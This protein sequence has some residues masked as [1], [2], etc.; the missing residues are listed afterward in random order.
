MARS[1]ARYTEDAGTCEAIAAS[2]C[3]WFCIALG[4]LVAGGIYLERSSPFTPEKETAQYNAAANTWNAGGRAAFAL[5]GPFQVSVAV[6]GSIVATAAA[7]TS[8]NLEQLLVPTGSGIAPFPASA[9]L[10][11]VT[12]VTPFVANVSVP[13]P[14]TK[15]DPSVSR[16]VVFTVSDNSGQVLFNR[17]VDLVSTYSYSNKHDCDDSPNA[18]RVGKRCYVYLTSTGGP[19]CWTITPAGNYG[20]GCS[21]VPLSTLAS[22]PLH[23]DQDLNFPA[24]PANGDATITASPVLPSFVNMSA[25]PIVLR[26]TL[27][28]YAA[29]VLATSGYPS[30]GERAAKLQTKGTILTAV[31]GR[32]HDGP[33]DD[34]CSGRHDMVEIL[35]L[36][37]V[38]LLLRR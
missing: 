20:G 32:R 36:C 15:T 2:A 35:S 8:S 5:A 29:F 37:S 17:S 26:S 11:Y 22:T 3:A 21:V 23:V 7:S 16:T 34:R 4:C 18:I 1:R 19:L 27:D 12:T 25:V 31:G 28:P 13:P 6:P 38:P 9:R 30:F 24:P 10:S 33:F 14:P